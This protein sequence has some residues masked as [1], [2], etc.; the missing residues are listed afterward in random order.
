MHKRKSDVVDDDA[1]DASNV[2]NAASSRAEQ[3]K[4]KKARTSKASES[5]DA[6]T[7]SVPT[8]GKGKGTK[9]KEPVPSR[10]WWEI[11]LEGEED[12]SVPVYD[13][14]NDIRRKIRALQQTPGFKI[15]HWFEKIGKINNNSYQRFMKATGPTGGA[16][17]GTYY[18]AYVYFEK[19][20][21]AE[22]KKKT[23]KRIHV[24]DE[25]LNGLP[26]VDRKH[27]WVIGSR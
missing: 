21:I 20:R 23:P 26:L 18:A 11:V 5:A 15:T 13:D 27:V 22:G 8:K 19:V 3:P 10:D 2:S 4:A 12:G 1:F 16:E 17:D 6:S 9:A 14:C 24:E 25:H 7:S